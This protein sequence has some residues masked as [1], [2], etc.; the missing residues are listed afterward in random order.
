MTTMLMTIIMVMAPSIAVITGIITGIA[1]DALPMSLLQLRAG[2]S[3]VPAVRSSGSIR[4]GPRLG[5]A[6]A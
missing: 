2:Q 5:S 6:K 1:P 4:A 3:I